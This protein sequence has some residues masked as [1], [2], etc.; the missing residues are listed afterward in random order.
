MA[1]KRQPRD[2]ENK[3]AGELQLIRKA[4]MHGYSTRVHRLEASLW[5]AQS[6]G[7]GATNYAKLLNVWRRAAAE[8]GDVIGP[9]TLVLYGVDRAAQHLDSA[10]RTELAW[11]VFCTKEREHAIDGVPAREIVRGSFVSNEVRNIK[12]DILSALLRLADE[13]PSRL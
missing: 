11:E 4:G 5:I 13:L 1:G 2:I 6:V 3:L 8:L 7:D 12:L 10:R 9:V